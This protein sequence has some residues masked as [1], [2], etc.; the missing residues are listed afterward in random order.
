[1]RRV[2]QL[3]FLV[4]NKKKPTPKRK[5]EDLNLNTFMARI[6]KH[7]YLTKLNTTDKEEVFLTLESIASVHKSFD[8][9]L[10][11]NAIRFVF[12]RTE[13]YT[14][15]RNWNIEHIGFGSYQ[16]AKC[17]YLFIFDYDKNETFVFINRKPYP[18]TELEIWEMSDLNYW[19]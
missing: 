9:Q 11:G 8:Y 7:K 13:R 3:G 14:F 2:N 12:E 5:I 18:E 16:R 4:V 19:G 10:V 1:M 17:S 15:A 6:N